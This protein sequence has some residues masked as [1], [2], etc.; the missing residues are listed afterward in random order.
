MYWW[1][2]RLFHCALNLPNDSEL[3]IK[4]NPGWECLFNTSFFSWITLLHISKL[5]HLPQ[6]PWVRVIIFKFTEF[7]FLHASEGSCFSRP[8]N[9]GCGNLGARPHSVWCRFPEAFVIKHNISTSGI[10]SSMKRVKVHFICVLKNPF[11]GSLG[12]SRLQ[13]F[14]RVWCWYTKLLLW[15]SSFVKNLSD[16]DCVYRRLFIIWKK[17]NNNWETRVSL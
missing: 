13:W 7:I 16:L 9:V 3:F 5:L 10:L 1:A 4:A 2:E 14:S 15:K 17:F 8:P 11:Y 12:I 6:S